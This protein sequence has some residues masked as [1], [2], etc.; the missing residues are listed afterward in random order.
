MNLSFYWLK[1]CKQTSLWNRAEFGHKLVFPW[2]IL[3]LL[4][5]LPSRH[6]RAQHFAN[7]FLLLLDCE[8]PQA[9]LVKI[10]WEAAAHP[11][12]VCLR[13]CACEQPHLL[14]TSGACSEHGL[15]GRVLFHHTTPQMWG[16]CGCS[17][18]LGDGD[19]LSVHTI[20]IALLELPEWSI[21]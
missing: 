15:S 20:C 1:T 21:F 10:S 12:C 11:V 6:G 3:W 8:A 16:K 5:E 9:P 7:S 13:A 17:K 4:Q 18:T 2:V 19:N 14:G